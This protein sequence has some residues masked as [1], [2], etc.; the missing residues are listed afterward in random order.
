MSLNRARKLFFLNRR[1]KNACRFW[2]GVA[3]L[4]VLDVVI[5]GLQLLTVMS[6]A[7]RMI[8]MDLEL[9]I[10]TLFVVE[11]CLRWYANDKEENLC[12]SNVIDTLVVLMSFFFA[13]FEISTPLL[14]ARSARFIRFARA[15]SRC[16]RN[17]R[18]SSQ[19][20]VEM[21]NFFLDARQSGAARARKI[22]RASE[23]DIMPLFLDI[24][25][26]PELATV[27]EERPWS[28]RHAGSRKQTPMAQSEQ[29]I[30]AASKTLKRGARAEIEKADAIDVRARAMASKAKARQRG[31]SPKLKHDDHSDNNHVLV[32]SSP[33]L[34]DEEDQPPRRIVTSTTALVHVLQHAIDQAD[35]HDE[36]P[37]RLLSTLRHPDVG[38][39]FLNRD[40]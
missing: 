13:L 14:A 22:A 19:S 25:T 10:S 40:I 2:S 37:P 30:L 3:L 36:P 39:V 4:T 38:L 6:D 29:P 20:A 8:L 9:G 27:F 24:T 28:S 15:S 1:K 21:R 34:P 12:A 26:A 31:A 7:T 35:A 18:K 5:F 17:A 16:G 33:L 32:V 23:E 11:L